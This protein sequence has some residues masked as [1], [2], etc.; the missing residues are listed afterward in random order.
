MARPKKVTK[1]KVM[2]K[3]TEEVSP[4]EPSQNFQ[5]D[6][7]KRLE[8][9]EARM[10]ELQ[11]ENEL[12]NKKLALQD[13]LVQ[14]PLAYTKQDTNKPVSAPNILPSFSEKLMREMEADDRMVEG[15]FE[16]KEITNPKEA[17]GATVTFHYRKYP[18]KDVQTYT[19]M[20]NQVCQLPVGVANHIN[21]QLGGCKYSIH[22]HV[23]DENGQPV[24]DI[25]GQEVHRMGFHTTTFA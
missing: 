20:H 21:G 2:E 4:A 24:R 12:L 25:A 18:G 10:G 15:K 6:L 8:G 3:A 11:K 9:F 16:F 19:L 23:M 22:K 17:K 5:A 13:K 7:I 14:D 1:E